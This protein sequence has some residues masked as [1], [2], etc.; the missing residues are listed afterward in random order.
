IEGDMLS[1]PATLNAS[2]VTKVRYQKRNGETATGGAGALN[3][4]EVQ[5]PDEGSLLIGGRAGEHIGF[6]LEAQIID[7]T[8]PAFASFKMPVVYG[9]D[10]KVSIIPFSTDSQGVAYSFELLN[11]GALRLMRPMEHRSQTSAQQYI[12]TSGAATG[13]A[14]VVSHSMFFANY[15]LWSP[16]HGTNSTGPNLNYLRLAATPTV[17]GWDL[18]VGVQ[19]WSGTSMQPGATGAGPTRTKAKAIALDAQAQG[20]AGSLPLGIYLTYAKADKSD[21]AGNDGTV[22]ANMFNAST[23]KAKSAMAIAV[24]AGV[25]PEKLT[26]QVAYLSGKNGDAAG[27]GNDK[28]NATTIGLNYNL[29][30]NASLQ[31]NH[32]WFTGTANKGSLRGAGNML[33]TLM[34]FAAF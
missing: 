32:S 20:S 1:M 33:T 12:G 30:Q 21:P 6:L 11:T 13:G 3:K 17:A 5:F 19:W 8:A 10:I 27:T 22:P 31:L 7:N 15:S 14:V 29:T 9:D 4:G 24:E 2:L 16:V 34:L 23:N 25:L 26:A 28:D 18:G